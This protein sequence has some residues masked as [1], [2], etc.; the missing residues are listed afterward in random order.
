MNQQAKGAAVPQAIQVQVQQQLVDQIERAMLESLVGFVLDGEWEA[1][2]AVPEANRR[3]VAEALITLMANP[4]ID[5]APCKSCQ[6]LR[7]LHP[8]NAEGVRP[9]HV[10]VDAEQTYFEPTAPRLIKL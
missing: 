1:G 8:L 9:C 10:E 5:E 6:R 4:A 7:L 3:I 2:Q